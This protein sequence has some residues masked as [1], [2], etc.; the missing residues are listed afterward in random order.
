MP[1]GVGAAIPKPP[2]TKTA[3]PSPNPKLLVGTKHLK[4]DRV[5]KRYIPHMKKE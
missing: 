1:P 2:A 5:T 4:A 3:N